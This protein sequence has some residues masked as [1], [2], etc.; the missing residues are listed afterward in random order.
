MK[1]E[2]LSSINEEIKELESELY[3]AEEEVCSIERCLE[4]LYDKKR[5]LIAFGDD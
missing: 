5:E 1:T 3:Y 4:R 2:T